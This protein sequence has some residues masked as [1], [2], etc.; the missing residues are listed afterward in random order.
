[1]TEIEQAIL[2]TQIRDAITHGVPAVLLFIAQLV[3][4]LKCDNKWIRL[5]PTF[6]VAGMAVYHLCVVAGEIPSPLMILS[7]P[8]LL[9]NVAP[10]LFGVGLAWAIY[11]IK[12]AVAEYRQ[13]KQ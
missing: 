12:I 4:C 10:S 5:V 8:Y 3:L 11:V 7:I 2:E 1:M 13:L 6:F 9:L